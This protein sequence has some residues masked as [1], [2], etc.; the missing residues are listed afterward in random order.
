MTDMTSC[1]TTN[2]NEHCTPSDIEPAPLHTSKKSKKYTADHCQLYGMLRFDF[3]FDENNQMYFDVSI[4]NDHVKYHGFL[5]LNGKMRDDV[6]IVNRK[7]VLEQVPYSEFVRLFEIKST[8]DT[9][10]WVGVMVFD[11]MF[12]LLAHKS[13]G[14]AEM[15]KM[16]LARHTRCFVWHGR[17]HKLFRMIGIEDLL[18]YIA[19]MTVKVPERIMMKKCLVYNMHT[20]KA[21][22]ERHGLH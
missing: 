13:K 8:T 4:V 15:L 3:A 20:L 11:L 16:D 6:M 17:Q 14:T 1:G 12:L 21:C 22:F 18:Y 10:S 9:G 19:I 7:N 2:D 5:D